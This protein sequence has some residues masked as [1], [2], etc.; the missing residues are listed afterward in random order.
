M[1]AFT[2]ISKASLTGL[3]LACLTFTCAGSSL[4]FAA[5]GQ[6]PGPEHPH[7]DRTQLP[8]EDDYSNTPFTEYGE[9]NEEEV[10]AAETKFFQYGRFFGFSLGMGYQGVTG[11]RGLLYQG[12]FPLLDMKL[13][14]WFDF[15][16][17]L[18]I[19]FHTAGNHFS[20]ADRGDIDVNILMVGID[21]K[22]YF[23]TK[24]LSAPIAASSPYLIVGFGPMTKTE[25]Y[26]NQSVTTP[27]ETSMGLAAGGG[28]EFTISP[29]RTFFELE[30]KFYYAKYND[31]YTQ[32]YRSLGID[33][34]TGLFY[35]VTGSVLFAW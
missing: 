21:L 15:N 29:R 28:L 6:A 4:A 11:G 3:L 8:E 17:A 34:L 32:V 10:E 25:H 26:A 31:T 20:T 13:H 2:F 14:Y 9:F 30:G 35:T 18:D 27:A 22:Y 24:N 5:E 1:P 16:L 19:N 7:S 12:G 33:D 23:D